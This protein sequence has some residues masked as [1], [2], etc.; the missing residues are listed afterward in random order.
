MT[1]VNYLESYLGGLATQIGWTTSGSSYDF[2]ISET[3]RL[4]GVDSEAEATDLNKLYVIGKR[5]LW[6]SILRE[7][8]FDYDYTAN[9]ASFKRSQMYDFIKQNLDDAAT[10][11]S[12][13]LGDYKISTG[14]L[15]GDAVDP[16]SNYPYED[17]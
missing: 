16:Y 7:V 12:Y 17:R 4:Y 6:E 8:S 3:L 10:E 11:A 5:V 2:T 15:G 1:L 9:G 14:V 13:Y